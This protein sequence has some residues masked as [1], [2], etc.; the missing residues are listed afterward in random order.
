MGS[1]ACRMRAR[2]PVGSGMASAG[3][4]GGGSGREANRRRWGKVLLQA[5]HRANRRR[6]R[7]PPDGVHREDAVLVQAARRRPVGRQRAAQD[8]VG[9]HVGI[10][11]RVDR[12]RFGEGFQQVDP[13]GKLGRPASAAP[14]AEEGGGGGLPADLYVCPVRIHPPPLDLEAEHVKR[15]EQRPGRWARG[16]ARRLSRPRRAAASAGESRR[17][18]RGLSGDARVAGKERLLQVGRAEQRGR[19]RRG[20]GLIAHRGR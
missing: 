12:Q 1:E 18:D 11:R 10:D 5:D 20:G 7:T 6:C 2:T 15:R 19:E 4:G 17:L 16:W 14:V 9:G 8:V 13:V 3:G